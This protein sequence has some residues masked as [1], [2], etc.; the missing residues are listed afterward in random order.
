MTTNKPRGEIIAATI[1]AMRALHESVDPLA[2]RVESLRGLEIDEDTRKAIEDGLAQFRSNLDECRS[3]IDDIANED[4]VTGAVLIAGLE[5]ITSKLAAIELPPRPEE[6]PDP[7][8]QAREVIDGAMSST[9]RSLDEILRGI[10]PTFYDSMSR[11]YRDRDE[12]AHGLTE[13]VGLKIHLPR[14]IENDPRGVAVG[15]EVVHLASVDNRRIHELMDNDEHAIELA[16]HFDGHAIA[17]V[18]HGIGRPLDEP[19]AEPVDAFTVTVVHPLG[20]E[21]HL[22]TRKPSSEWEKASAPERIEITNDEDRRRIADG[23]YGQIPSGLARFYANYLDA[24]T[25]KH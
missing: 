11:E 24:V 25:R 1:E 19:D 23:E 9:M 21:S 12:E 3:T 20:I 14:E 2:E 13:I 10:L 18:Q 8:E 6:V 7:I 15:V 16:N 4:R 22:E 17:L 5:A